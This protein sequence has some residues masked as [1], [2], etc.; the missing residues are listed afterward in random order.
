[1]GMGVSDMNRIEIDKYWLLLVEIEEAWKEGNSKSICV[2]TN[3][4]IGF[5]REL[6]EELQFLF[7]LM[8]GKL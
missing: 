1:M 4:A 5:D 6:A 7:D 8:C 2:L 3:S